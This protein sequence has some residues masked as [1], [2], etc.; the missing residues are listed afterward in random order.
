M[1]AAKLAMDLSE[2]EKSDLV[3]DAMKRLKRINLQLVDVL[4]RR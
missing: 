1:R 4:Y 3:K 2:L